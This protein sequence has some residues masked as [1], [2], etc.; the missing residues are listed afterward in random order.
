V[1]VVSGLNGTAGVP[2]LDFTTLAG[3]GVNTWSREF[4]VVL[5][6]PK[7]G[8][9]LRQGQAHRLEVVPGQEPADAVEYRAGVGQKGSLGRFLR[10]RCISLRWAKVPS[11]LTVALPVL[12]GSGPEKVH[13]A[14]QA[15]QVTKGPGPG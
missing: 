1:P 8:G 14:M 13:L 4:Q 12:P 6:T 11:D 10:G 3:N 5:G 7:E 9:C 2:D 15:L